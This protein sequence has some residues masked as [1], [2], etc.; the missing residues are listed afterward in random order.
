[1][2]TVAPAQIIVLNVTHVRRKK[3]FGLVLAGIIGTVAVATSWWRFA[4]H[5]ATLR[6]LPFFLYSTL[7][8]TRDTLKILQ[9]S[10]DPLAG[11]A[12][13]N[14]HAL[15]YLLA[16]QGRVCIV[17]NK[18]CCTYINVSGEEEVNV[19]GIYEQ[20]SWL[21]RY[22]QGKQEWT[23]TV[24]R[25]FSAY[26]WLPPFLRPIATVF[27]TLLFGPCIFNC[28]ANFLS[29]RIQLQLQMMLWR[30]FQP[31]PP[32]DGD[33]QHSLDKTAHLLYTS[34]STTANNPY[35]W[36]IARRSG[37]TGKD[38]TPAQVEAVTKDIFLAHFPL[39]IF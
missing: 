6:D 38:N 5:E 1:M 14:F 35:L 27:L 16:S 12:F 19:K 22:N 36:Q 17:I 25:L 31:I 29:S 20:A 37:S 13:D 3:A 34:L 26:T 4:Y 7:K 23:K 30:G 8:K 11:I 33:R 21:H 32:E 9:K 10:L 18:M 39:K 15:D 24:K 28:L 2:G